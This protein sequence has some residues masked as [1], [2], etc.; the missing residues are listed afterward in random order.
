MSKNYL[1]K[2]RKKVKISSKT[3]Y[4]FQSKIE[5]IDYKDTTTLQKFIN[6]QGRIV[7]RKYTKLTAKTQ[8]QVARA[9]ERARQMA[10][11]PHLIV[12]QK[13]KN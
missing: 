9:I 11:L 1:G 5:Y 8:R 13:E 3:D 10:L 4:F 6:S 7:K 12:E 2:K